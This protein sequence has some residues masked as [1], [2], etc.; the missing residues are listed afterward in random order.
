MTSRDGVIFTSI[1]KNNRLGRDGL[2]LAG[3]LGGRSAE[4]ACVHK[5]P[6]SE[7]PANLTGCGRSQSWTCKPLTSLAIP[8]QPLFIIPWDK[9]K[10]LFFAKTLTEKP[11]FIF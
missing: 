2:Q 4:S 8:F 5:Q 11:G 6:V 9:W 7:V 1:Q 10:F 3:L